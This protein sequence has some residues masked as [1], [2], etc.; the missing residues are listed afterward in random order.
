MNAVFP[1]IPGG[2]DARSP[3]GH[4]DRQLVSLAGKD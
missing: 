3:T 2:Q 4:T 1:H